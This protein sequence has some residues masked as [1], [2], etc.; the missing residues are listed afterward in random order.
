MYCPCSLFGYL[1]PFV[2]RDPRRRAGFLSTHDPR[3]GGRKSPEWENKDCWEPSAS[4]F[5]ACFST[6]FR[7]QQFLFFARWTMRDTGTTPNISRHVPSPD[8][9][10]APFMALFL[11][12]TLYCYWS[13]AIKSVPSSS[14]ISTDKWWILPTSKIWSWHFRKFGWKRKIILFS[15]VCLGNII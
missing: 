13:E 1:P 6:V 15:V 8:S 4:F 14:G 7:N 11:A 12:L 2:P 10:H 3:E 9:L 5:I